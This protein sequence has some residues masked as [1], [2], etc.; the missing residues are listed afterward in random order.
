MSLNLLDSLDSDTDVLVQE[1]AY[2]LELQRRIGSN[3][4]VQIQENGLNTI[5]DSLEVTPV[6]VEDEQTGTEEEC[7]R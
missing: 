2:Q 1:R 6:A 3:G 7:T 5:Y 4:D